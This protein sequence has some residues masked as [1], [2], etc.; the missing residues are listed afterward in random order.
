MF[1]ETNASP[2]PDANSVGVSFVAKVKKSKILWNEI[3]MV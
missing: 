3:R 2:R 1:V